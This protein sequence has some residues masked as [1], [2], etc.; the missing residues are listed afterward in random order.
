M[1]RAPVAAGKN[2]KSVAWEN[3]IDPQEICSGR[4]G[5]PPNIMHDNK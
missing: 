5:K 4:K 1:S 3:S 2:I